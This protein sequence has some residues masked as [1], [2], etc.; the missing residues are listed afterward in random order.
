MNKEEWALVEQ[1]MKEIDAL[2]PIKR[3]EEWYARTHDLPIGSAFAILGN[4]LRE[5]AIEQQKKG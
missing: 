2:S 1:R 5:W 3:I 4:A